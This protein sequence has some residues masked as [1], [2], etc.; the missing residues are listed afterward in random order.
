MPFSVVKTDIIQNVK[1]TTQ[2]QS[3]IFGRGKSVEKK[4]KKTENE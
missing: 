4:E 1:T 3:F 2:L